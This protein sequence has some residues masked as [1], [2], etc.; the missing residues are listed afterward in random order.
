M[1]TKYYILEAN[2]E[3]LANFKN[4][5]L[6]NFYFI[7]SEIIKNKDGLFFVKNNGFIKAKKIK[8]SNNKNKLIQYLIK[9]EDGRRS[10][11]DRK[12]L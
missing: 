7:V 1:T 6:T 10:K 5:D 11:I 2:K 3:D 12:R 9:K 8:Q 4:S